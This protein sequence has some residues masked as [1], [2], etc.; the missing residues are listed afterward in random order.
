MREIRAAILDNSFTC[1]KENFLKNYKPTNEQARI[2]QKKMWWQTRR[3][4]Q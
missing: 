4:E 1:F 2:Y 3:R